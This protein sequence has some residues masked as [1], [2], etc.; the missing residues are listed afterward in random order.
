M[1]ERTSSG[2][3][4]SGAPEGEVWVWRN[5]DPSVEDGRLFSTTPE[6]A[7]LVVRA[8]N[9]HDDL[10]AALNVLLAAYDVKST[11]RNGVVYDSRAD[12]GFAWRN[13]LDA[14]AKAEQT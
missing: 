14:I 8:V 4:G 12:A 13:A 1:S 10:L 11:A 5:V 6:V 2:F 9:A 3:G 7:E